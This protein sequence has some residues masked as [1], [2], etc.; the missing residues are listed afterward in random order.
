MT[1]TPASRMGLIIYRFIFPALVVF[2]VLATSTCEASTCFRTGLPGKEDKHFTIAP[3]DPALPDG[4]CG[5]QAGQAE[6]RKSATQGV[7][8]EL[9]ESEEEW[10]K[11]K[12]ADLR[13]FTDQDNA[14]EFRL[15]LGEEF[16]V[17]LPENPTT[18]FLWTVLETS[19]P[20]IELERKEFSP[21]QDSGI[22]G[23]GGIR[24]LIFKATKPGRAALHLGLKRP[25]EKDGKCAG[26]YSLNLVVE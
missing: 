14:K 15:G 22:V 2:S 10:K 4:A 5:E 17:Q 3:L 20:N 21:P 1:Y 7:G 24:V 8:K 23:A 12:V 26:T 18:G 11:E 9:K 13:T 6:S 19:S 16:R 25:W